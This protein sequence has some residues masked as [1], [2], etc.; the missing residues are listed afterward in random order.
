MIIANEVTWVVEIMIDIKNKG[1]IEGGYKKHLK[2]Y[3]I[4]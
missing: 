4:M 2:G 3:D 1:I